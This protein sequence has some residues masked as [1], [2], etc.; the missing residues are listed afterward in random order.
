MRGSMAA[1]LEEWLVGRVERGGG[2]GEGSNDLL[3]VHRRRHP[4][5]LTPFIF[6]TF[7]P[8]LHMLL[9]CLREETVSHPSA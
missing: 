2:R 1:E 7:W 9:E 8:D 5:S 6:C 4:E 3:P